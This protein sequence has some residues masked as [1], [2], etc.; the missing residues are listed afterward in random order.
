[1][2][3]QARAQAGWLER[4]WL[5]A[6]GILVVTARRTEVFSGRVSPRRPFNRVRGCQVTELRRPALLRKQGSRLSRRASAICPRRFQPCQKNASAGTATST[7]S[8]ESGRPS[9]M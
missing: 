3:R 2:H 6:Q 9:R 4:V 7:T 8:S 1:M 5:K